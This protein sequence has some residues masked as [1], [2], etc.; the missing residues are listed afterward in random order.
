MVDTAVSE[1]T[2]QLQVQDALQFQWPEI[3]H[4]QPSTQV[5]FCRLVQSICP[6]CG[7]TSEQ[8]A[9]WARGRCPPPNSMQSLLSLCHFKKPHS[10][11]AFSGAKQQ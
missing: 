2:G 1:A 8:G 10:G 7:H 4:S 11:E 3:R 9:G 5:P 6:E